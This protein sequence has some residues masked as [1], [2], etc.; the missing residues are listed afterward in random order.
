[1]RTPGSVVLPLI[2]LGLAIPSL[3]RAD[4]DAAA[5][6]SPSSNP[7]GVWSYGQAA[8]L[9]GPFALYTSHG[10]TSGIDYWGVGSVFSDPVVWHNGTSQPISLS[11]IVFQPGQLAFH[12]G[13]QDQFSVV[14]FTS[15]VASSFALTSSFI[16]IDVGGTTTDVHVLLNGVSLFNGLINGYGSTTAYGS[17]IT[18]A[19][20]DTLDFE[21]GYGANGNYF[22]DATGISAHLSPQS[23]PEPGSIALLGV[24]LAG[25]FYVS[26]R[27]RSAA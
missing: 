12:P 22:N 7:N 13:P 25:V 8:T 5:D 23:V 11:T 24:G 1:M 26:K 20:G 4:F 17:T 16:G 10:N 2:A 3:A 9:G 27:R 15:P 21:V 19:A 14:R 6:F 18:L